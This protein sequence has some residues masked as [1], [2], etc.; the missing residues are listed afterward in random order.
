MYEFLGKREVVSFSVAEGSHKIP[1]KK[2]FERKTVERQGFLKIITETVLPDGSLTQL[3]TEETI[4]DTDGTFISLTR[5]SYQFKNN[6]KH[7]K[8]TSASTGKT[9]RKGFV[10]VAITETANLMERSKDT[11]ANKS[12]RLANFLKGD[13]SSAPSIL[14]PGAG[15]VKQYFAENGTPHSTS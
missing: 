7:G 4:L 8:Y 11:S 1:K 10:W 15:I 12:E 14:V 13:L 9:K 3:L 5:K 6:E 2:E